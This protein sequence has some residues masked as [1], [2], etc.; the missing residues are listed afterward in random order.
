MPTFE[1][2]D[3]ISATIDVVLGDVRIS[4]GD[5]GHTVVDVRPTDGSN[6]EDRK[7]AEQ[8]RVE[9]AG[10]QLLV[11]APKL[12]S[13]LPR[14]TG[15]SIDV[16]DRAARRLARARLRR[17]WPTSTATARSASAGSGRRRPHRRRD[18]RTA[19]RSRAAPATSPS[20]RATGHADISTGSGDVRVRELDGTA[21]IKNSNGDTWVGEARGDLRVNAANGDIAVDHAHAT[22][23]A[24]SSNGDVRLGEVVR[25]AVVLETRLGDLEVGIREGTAA[26]LD[27]R[28][29]AGRVR[30]ALEAAEAPDA[31]RRDRRGARAHDVRRRG[32]SAHG[33]MT[34]PSAIARPACAS[35][36]A[37]TSS[38]T[39]STSTSPRAPC[40]RCSAR[41]APA[42]PRSCRSSR[43]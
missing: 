13:W 10:G 43:R 14:S 16:D 15:G 1:T 27:V 17:R 32:R 37:T 18:G 28:A 11:K 8:T 22:V 31:V 30:N 36:T 39:A 34:R 26:W 24:K 2:P 12:R 40:S 29:A 20:T 42:R 3:P 6:D 25:G 35:P 7:A 33:R 4:A 19:R 9:Y 38:S 41:T 21:V 23:V 5:R